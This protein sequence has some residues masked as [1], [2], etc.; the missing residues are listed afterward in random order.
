MFL[1][2]R[3]HSE[4]ASP[5]ISGTGRQEENM[6]FRFLKTHKKIALYPNQNFFVEVN[7]MKYRITWEN[8][9]K[10]WWH[11]HFKIWTSIYRMA[12]N[13]QQKRNSDFI[14]KS[15]QYF[16]FK[17]CYGQ[18]KTR[19]SRRW[20]LD[21]WYQINEE[22]DFPKHNLLALNTYVQKCRLTRFNALY[23]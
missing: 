17:L 13:Y 3:H 7:C 12:L 14:L 19:V 18:Y 21:Q 20:L 15:P 2:L 8:K 9:K 22:L 23:E 5:V 11:G 6:I 16:C 10:I 4:H 1:N